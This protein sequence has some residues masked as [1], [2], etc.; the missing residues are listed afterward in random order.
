MA[1]YA[2]YT[3]TTMM[4]EAYTAYGYYFAYNHPKSREK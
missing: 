1:K 2:V 4:T 3:M